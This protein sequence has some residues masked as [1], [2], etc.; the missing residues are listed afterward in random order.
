MKRQ[1]GREE[2]KWRQISSKV[3]VFSSAS[4]YLRISALTYDFYTSQFHVILRERQKGAVMM[5]TV[6]VALELPRGVFSALRQDPVNFVAEI[7]GAAAVKWYEMRRLSQ[8]KAPEVA[9]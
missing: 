7:R 1:N 4:L 3:F 5:E 2:W 6:K 9:A 8:A